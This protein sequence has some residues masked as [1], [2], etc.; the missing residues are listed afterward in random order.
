MENTSER[1]EPPKGMDIVKHR[2]ESL[3]K[4]IGERFG[5]RHKRLARTFENSHVK[6]ARL[7]NNLKFM[8]RCRNENLIPRGMR[9]HICKQDKKNSNVMKLIKKTE[10][11]RLRKHIKDTR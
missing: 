8:K 3:F 7:Q 9:S 2:K 1:K 10:I 4:V 11:V 5:D 6:R